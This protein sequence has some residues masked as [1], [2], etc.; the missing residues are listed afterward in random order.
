VVLRLI[1]G[2]LKM[3]KLLTQVQEVYFDLCDLLNSGEIDDILLT[4]FQEF[5]TLKEFLEEQKT[6]LAE[7][8]KEVSK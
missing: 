3:T 2:A 5:E 6:K 8:E 7:I 4:T 1:K